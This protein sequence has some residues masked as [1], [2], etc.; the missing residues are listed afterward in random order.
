MTLCSS[1][2]KRTTANPTIQTSTP[3]P[4]T[5]TFSSSNSLAFP[6]TLSLSLSLSLPN[7]LAARSSLSGQSHS[8]VRRQYPR[9]SMPLKPTLAISVVHQRSLSPA[10][11][12]QL[13][14]RLLMGVLVIYHLV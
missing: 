5:L 3:N 14:R 7:S 8:F 11:N 10:T 9:T 1:K 12:H 4:F 2:I 6:F 13:H